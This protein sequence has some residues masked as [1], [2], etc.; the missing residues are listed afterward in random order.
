R[1]LDFL[2]QDFPVLA[3]VLGDETFYELA[4][5]YVQAHPPE[6]PNPRYAGERMTEYL[7][8]RASASSPEDAARPPWLPDLA[9][10]EWAMVDVFDAE[11]SPVLSLAALQTRPPETWSALPLRFVPA[12]RALDLAFN[13]H[14]PWIAAHERNDDASKIAPPI[15]EPT[16][17]LVWR[18]D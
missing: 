9:S 13:V 8:D 3:R 11:D 12:L 7:R 5:D 15:A 1:L 14:E 18:H 4:A 6:N 10:F 17:I 16:R 2:R